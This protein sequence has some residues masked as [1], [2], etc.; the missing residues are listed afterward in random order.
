MFWTEIEIFYQ[1]EEFAATGG[2]LM[3]VLMLMLMLMLMFIIIGVC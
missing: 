3:L 2:P 1:E